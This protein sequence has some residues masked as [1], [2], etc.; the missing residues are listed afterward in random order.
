MLCGY[1]LDHIYK[2]EIEIGEFL[3]GWTDMKRG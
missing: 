3:N 1:V 2:G